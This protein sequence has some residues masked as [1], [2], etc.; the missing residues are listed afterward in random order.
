MNLPN[1]KIFSKS[2]LSKS[3]SSNKN[4]S[5]P[6]KQH[7]DLKS[8]AGRSNR[9]TC[10]KHSLWPLLF[11]GSKH[12]KAD[13]W[14]CCY[15][16]PCTCLAVICYISGG[17]FQCMIFDLHSFDML[18]VHPQNFW[19]FPGWLT[20]FQMT[21]NHPSRLLSNQQKISPPKTRSFKRLERK[22]MLNL[23]RW[24][25]KRGRKVEKMM[26]KCESAN[27]YMGVSEN[28]GTPKSSILIGC[29]IINH[30]FFVILGGG[31]QIFF[32][33]TPYLGKIPI[34][35]NIFQRGW[36][37]QLV[38]W[39]LP[40]V[41]LDI[42]GSLKMKGIGILRGSPIRI[43]NHQFT[44]SW[45]KKSRTKII[46]GFVQDSRSPKNGCFMS[47]WRFFEG[48]AHPRV[49]VGRSNV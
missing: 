29:S 32:I 42:W 17:V 30:Q 13:S 5:I 15:V 25:S 34:L 49:Q 43:P 44:N 28:S 35:T 45:V 22:R 19:S 3:V 11:G 14:G 2:W 18:D 33:L 46:K 40:V 38:N 9:K 47:S 26:E 1:K 39:F 48:K 4:S 7:L 8:L 20:F 6:K 27:G 10:W 37:H 24:V 36:N 21:W 31:F 41:G 23:K 12:P 16:L